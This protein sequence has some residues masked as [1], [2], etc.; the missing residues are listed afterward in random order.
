MKPQDKMA[1][2]PALR[3]SPRSDRA[4]QAQN[5]PALS[6][7]LGPRVHWLRSRCAA[8]PAALDSGVCTVIDNEIKTLVELKNSQCYPRRE[9][10]AKRLNPP[11]VKDGWEPEKTHVRRPGI[12]PG[13][14]EWE[15]CMIPLHQRRCWALA[16]LKSFRTKYTQTIVLARG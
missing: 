1:A 6:T 8:G 9:D 14:Q 3:S 11:R 5:R 10:L 4:A 12:E 15:S 7:P 2:S 13:S 16:S